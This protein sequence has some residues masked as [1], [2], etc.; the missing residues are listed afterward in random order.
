MKTTGFG[1]VGELVDPFIELC[2][3]LWSIAVENLRAVNH[4]I[5]T[6]AL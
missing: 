2:S 6:T 5:T 1:C 3:I 4:L